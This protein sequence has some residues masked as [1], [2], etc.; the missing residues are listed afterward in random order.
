MCQ[1][2]WLYAEVNI[3]KRSQKASNTPFKINSSYIPELKLCTADASIV[4]KILTIDARIKKRGQIKNK[5][6]ERW[7]QKYLKVFLNTAKE[8]YSWIRYSSVFRI[9]QSQQLI[10]NYHYNNDDWFEY[11]VVL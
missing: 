8:I 11:T 7:G 2:E 6:E 5:V 4:L 3:Y 9:I 10:N 1:K